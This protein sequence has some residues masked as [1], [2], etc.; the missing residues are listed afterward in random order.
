[1]FSI[2]IPTW[3]NLEMLRLCVE[4]IE[5]H[6]AYPHQ[7]VL[8]INDGSDGTLDWAK[9]KGLAHTHSPQN[10]GICRAVNLAFDKATADY[11]MYMNDDMYAL[12]NWDT[13]LVAALQNIDSD[14]FMLSSTMIE[15]TPPNSANVIFGDYG[16]D[17][18][19]FKKEALLADYAAFEMGDWN[20]ASWPPLLIPRTAWL[21]I[22][23]FSL[24]FSPGMYSD[25]DFSM[26]LWH[27]GCRIFKGVGQSRVYHFQSRST[28]R[29]KKNNGRLTFMQKWGLPASAFYKYYLKMATPGD[30]HLSTPTAQKALT[31]ARLKARFHAFKGH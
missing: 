14:V 6:S 25:P 22:G 1:M 23:G 9:A 11:I 2:I 31:W 7:I 17:V 13:H 30:G 19:T 4:S 20:G 10:I 8:H 12:P 21:A 15:P 24:E 27:L 18:T 28:G 26:K 3:N 5:T 16:R 29:I